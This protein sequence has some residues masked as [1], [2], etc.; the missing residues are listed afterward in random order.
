ML[1][2]PGR[3]PRS[4]ILLYWLMRYT[5]CHVSKAAGILCRTID[6]ERNIF[7]LVP[8]KLRPLKNDFRQRTIPIIEPLAEVLKEL[9]TKS[10]KPS[11]H[12]FPKFYEKQYKRLGN[13]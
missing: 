11:D 7:H 13:G 2:R 1:A 12:I 4:Q 6:L 10:K 3:I 8:N 5:G 9:D